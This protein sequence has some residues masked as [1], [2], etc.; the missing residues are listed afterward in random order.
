MASLLAGITHERHLAQGFLHH[1]LKVAPEVTIYQEDIHRALVVGHEDITA[2]LV[3]V[4]A[5]LDADGQQQH[6]ARQPRPHLAGIVAP[7]MGIAQNAAYDGEE[8][9]DD[10]DH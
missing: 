7:E 3:D 10:G 1:P 2:V 5:P 4:F 8:G 9:C 6:A